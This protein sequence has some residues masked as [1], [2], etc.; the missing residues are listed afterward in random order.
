MTHLAVTISS[1]TVALRKQ[2]KRYERE[3]KDAGHPRR[4]KLYCFIQ[5]KLKQFGNWFFTLWSEEIQ[6]EMLKD[7][8]PFQMNA[9][10][11]TTLRWINQPDW[12]QTDLGLKRHIEPISLNGKKD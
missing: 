6:A 9:G 1:K 5:H 4:Q 8:K 3:A 10:E 2:F 7:A 11:T 12:M